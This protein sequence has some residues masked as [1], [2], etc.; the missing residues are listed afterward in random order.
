MSSLHQK[1]YCPVLFKYE[2]H[3]Q[4]G[5]ARHLQLKQHFFETFILLKQKYYLMCYVF[6]EYFL[7]GTIYRQMYGID[8]NAMSLKDF[9]L[10]KY[11]LIFFLP[12]FQNV[13]SFKYLLCRALSKLHE[14][15]II[16]IHYIN[17]LE[18]TDILIDPH[19]VIPTPF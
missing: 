8:Y 3:K 7:N 10:Y 19:N 2:V 16:H 18:I 17:I 14:I 15:I 5:S 6:L 11:F 12:Y 1:Q 4:N 13:D 9:H